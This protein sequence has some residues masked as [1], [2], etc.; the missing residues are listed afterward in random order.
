MRWRIRI[1]ILSALLAGGTLWFRVLAADQ[2]RTIQTFVGGSTGQISGQ[3]DY[4]FSLYIGDDIGLVTNPIKSNAFSVSGVYTG[5]GTINFKV[6][7]SAA[8]SKTF[9]FPNVGSTPTPF[10]ILYKDPDN[11]ISPTSAGLF[12]HTLNVTPSGITISGLGAILTTTYRYNQGACHD[13]TTQKIKTTMTFVG[14]SANQVSSP[15]DKQFVL[16]IGDDL[17][18]VSNPI[19]SNF[20]T[21]GGVYTGSGTL[22]LMIDSDAASSK[23]FTLPNVGS[24][25]TF[26]QV[27]YKDTVSKID[28]PSSGAFTHTLNVTPS[29]ITI[30][31]LGAILTTTY[32]YKPP[33]CGGL[34]PTGELTS[35]VFDATASA[36]YN[37]FVWK[38]TVNGGSGKVRFQ[39]ATSNS[40]SGPWN[41]RAGAG[42]GNG[43][44][45]DPGS[46]DVSVEISCGPEYHNN[47]RYFK[48]K[49]QLCSNSDCSTAGSFSPRVDDVIVNWSP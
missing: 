5:S 13:G 48:Y 8:S 24:T 7:S 18:G 2:F 21:V 31:G 36:A 10:Q 39:L 22:Q 45:Y 25:P 33:S 26:F 38:G 9:T 15:V 42:C 27:H 40:P 43:E 44:W 19:K 4:A 37:S 35:A 34:P 49:V 6:D 1:I 16:Y 23:T 47:Q 29:G 20:F 46:P 11:T 12:N 28:P 41:F 14:D 30:S 17:S 32:R 3:V